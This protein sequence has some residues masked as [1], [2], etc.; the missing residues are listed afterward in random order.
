MR[1]APQQR[2]KGALGKLIRSTRVLLGSSQIATI[3]PGLKFCR[4]TWSD[5][6]I[7]I[8]HFERHLEGPER[9]QRTRLAAQEAASRPPPRTTSREGLGP[10]WLILGSP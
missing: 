6:K 5:F 1:W 2:Q 9:V 10:S 4:K 8:P 7:L 3:W